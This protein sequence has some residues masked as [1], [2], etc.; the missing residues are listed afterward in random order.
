MTVSA[1]EVLS[2]FGLDDKPFYEAVRALP[3]SDVQAI[4]EAIISG[5]HFVPF[6]RL[7]QT[8]IPFEEN[9]RKCVAHALELLYGLR[10]R[11]LK[12]FP[13]SKRREL[14]EF[15]RDAIRWRFGLEKARGLLAK[16]IIPKVSISVEISTGEHEEHLSGSLDKR[17]RVDF[18]KVTRAMNGSFSEKHIVGAIA[19]LDTNIRR[20]MDR[21]TQFRRREFRRAVV[22]NQTCHFNAFLE[23]PTSSAYSLHPTKLDRVV[24]DIYSIDLMTYEPVL[25]S[26]IKSFSRDVRADYDRGAIPSLEFIEALRDVEEIEGDTNIDE[27]VS[28]FEELRRTMLVRG[29]LQRGLIIHETDI[30]KLIFSWNPDQAGSPVRLRVVTNIQNMVCRQLCEDPSVKAWYDSH[31]WASGSET[32]FIPPQY[33]ESYLVQEASVCAYLEDSVRGIYQDMVQQYLGLDCSVSSIVVSVSQFEVCFEEAFNRKSVSPVAA[34]SKRL[35]G[36]GVNS[37]LV[38]Y[39]MFLW[40]DWFSKVG[41]YANLKFEVG[42]MRPMFYCDIPSIDPTLPIMQYKEYPKFRNDKGQVMIRH[43]F[44]PTRFSKYFSP[45]GGLPLSLMVL[46]NPPFVR[47]MVERMFQYEYIHTRVRG[48]GYNARFEPSEDD[49]VDSLFRSILGAAVFRG[50]AGAYS[51]QL[52]SFLDTGLVPGALSKEHKKRMEDLGISSKVRRGRYEATAAFRSLSSMRPD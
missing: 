2:V 10:G 27:V 45:E 40:L 50:K 18:P 41:S 37:E 11:R 47:E 36:T 22:K 35:R 9:Y 33:Y 32:N 15:L 28:H 3:V 23:S 17:F 38:H 46:T 20:S 49:D 21:M 1:Q 7:M 52:S 42:S 39:F 29:Y 8:V 26:R 14:R 25:Q 5:E 16:G 34:I 51:A 44:I 30:G 19:E 24:I 12:E 4:D 48:W 31:T 13:E 6:V 43:E